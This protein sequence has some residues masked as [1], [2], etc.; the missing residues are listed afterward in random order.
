MMSAQ[1][2][3]TPKYTFFPIK[4]VNNIRQYTST[5]E[6]DLFFDD[7]QHLRT[8]DLQKNCEDKSDQYIM[9]MHDL[10]IFFKKTRDSFDN[11]RDNCYEF[12]IYDKRNI[13]TKEY[14][15]NVNKVLRLLD[16]SVALDSHKSMFICKSKQQNDKLYIFIH[17]GS[18]SSRVWEYTDQLYM[19]EIDNHSSSSSVIKT[20]DG[21]IRINSHLV[22]HANDYKIHINVFINTHSIDT[23]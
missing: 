13:G 14:S 2:F 20:V 12:D 19:I 17:N 16:F 7:I 22:K 8:I 4:L 1:Y 21:C 11:Y 15:G 9:R 6:M 23:N 10:H 3:E 18:M 5:I